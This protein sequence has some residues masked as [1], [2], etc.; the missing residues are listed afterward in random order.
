MSEKRNLLGWSVGYGN[1]LMIGEISSE[2]LVQKA[3]KW[4]SGY[5]SYRLSDHVE[6]GAFF[7]S[8]KSTEEADEEKISSN[9]AFERTII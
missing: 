9:A 7:I 2:E 8:T 4:A 6:M 5:K 3:W 1:C